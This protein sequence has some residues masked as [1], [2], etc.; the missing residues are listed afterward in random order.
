MAYDEG[1]AQRIRESFDEQPGFV[2]K[3]MFGGLCFLLQGNMACGV[4]K[5]ELIAR[6]GPYKYETALKKPHTKKFDITG[7]PMKG[8]VVVKSEGLEADDDLAA[9]VQEG[10]NYALSLPAK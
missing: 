4:L 8:W 1:L 6:V 7:R 10:I 9:W 5:D 2:E 3:K